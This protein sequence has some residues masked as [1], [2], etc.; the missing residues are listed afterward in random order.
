[1]RQPLRVGF[2]LPQV[3]SA[4]IEC[5]GSRGVGI[6]GASILAAPWTSALPTHATEPRNVVANEHDI[7][8]TTAA[9]PVA[10][11]RKW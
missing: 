1:M 3:V 10:G 6:D 2:V 8:G 11:C 7:T 4:E 5:T 9:A